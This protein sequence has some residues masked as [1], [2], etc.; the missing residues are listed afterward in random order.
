MRESAEAAARWTNPRNTPLVRWWYRTGA[1]V[2][3]PLNFLRH[4][5]FLW[6]MTELS[7]LALYVVF[8]TRS[9]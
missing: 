8:K 1:L 5:G 9:I 7:F 3:E 4:C 6:L 2:S